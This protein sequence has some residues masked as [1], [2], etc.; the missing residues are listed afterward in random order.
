[1]PRAKKRKIFHTPCV[2]VNM[3]F[4]F[5]YDNYLFRY[6]EKNRISQLHKSIIINNP[7][8]LYAFLSPINATTQKR[9]L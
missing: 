4:C 5:C 8:T 7:F 2:C 3:R 6:R 9:R 1:M